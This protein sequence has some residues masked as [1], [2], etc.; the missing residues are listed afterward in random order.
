MSDEK[1]RGSAEC[2]APFVYTIT[3]TDKEFILP[4]MEIEDD[5]S[6]TSHNV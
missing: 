1:K 3:N 2:I 5:T 6:E 4:E